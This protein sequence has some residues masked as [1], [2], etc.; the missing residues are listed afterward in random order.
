M[1][2]FVVR[3]AQTVKKNYR[4]DDYS[5]HELVDRLFKRPIAYVAAIR[6][7]QLT[8]GEQLPVEKS[9]LRVVARSIADL[10][11]RVAAPID[12]PSTSADDDTT[13]GDDTTTTST[14]AQTATSD[15]ND[16][17]DTSDDLDRTSS[18]SSSSRRDLSRMA[19][20]AVSTTPTISIDVA[21]SN[22]RLRNFAGLR[23]DADSRA[24][25]RARRSRE[26]AAFGY[27]DF[28]RFG[29]ARDVLFSGFSR[30]YFS[31]AAYNEASDDERSRGL[32]RRW[33]WRQW[34]QHDA[35][36]D[37]VADGDEHDARGV[38]GAH[39]RGE[40]APTSASQLGRHGRQSADSVSRTHSGLV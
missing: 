11:S 39:V 12:A 36:A 24:R 21:Q 26:T 27:R 10:A 32:C 1:L 38:V 18:S 20:F 40:R 2:T 31:A 33:R 37:D 29:C 30:T 8:I 5:F 19:S 14:T 15:D 6:D 34:R 16:A 13:S 4:R 35:A 25:R 3:S 17:E 9:A 23:K 28:P 7:A 22:A